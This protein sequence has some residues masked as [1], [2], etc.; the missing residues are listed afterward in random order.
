MYVASVISPRILYKSLFD[1]Q[2]MIETH[3]LPTFLAGIQWKHELY[4]Y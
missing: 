3:N 4:F 2:V 1:S